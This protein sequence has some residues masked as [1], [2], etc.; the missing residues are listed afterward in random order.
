LA[1]SQLSKYRLLQAQLE[2]AE[3]R[4]SQAEN[5]LSKT[6]LRAHSTLMT[7]ARGGLVRIF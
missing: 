2:E 4:V 3:E 7:G 5:A 6:R 1:Q